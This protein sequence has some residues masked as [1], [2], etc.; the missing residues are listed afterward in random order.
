MAKLIVKKFGAGTLIEVIIAM[1]IIMV[2]FGIALKVFGNLLYSG[3]S[4][5]KVEVQ[6]QLDVLAME[7][8]DRGFIKE[9]MMEIDSVTYHFFTD[10]SA[11]SG[12][13]KLEIQAMQKDKLLS[14]INC[15]YKEKTNEA[16]N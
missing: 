11:V 14:K 4:Y 15:F 13:S 9:E 1:V 12:V 10:T 6:N 8:K 16:E 3:V 2:V 7:I 5:Q